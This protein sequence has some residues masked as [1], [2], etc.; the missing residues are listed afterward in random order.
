MG[1]RAIQLANLL[2]SAVGFYASRAGLVLATT[3]G[4][5]VTRLLFS[6]QRYMA[7]YLHRIGEQLDKLRFSCRIKLHTR[8]P[9]NI[10]HQLTG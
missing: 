8:Q 4:L 7:H 10:S 1:Y 2:K 6:V 9:A 3:A 5:I